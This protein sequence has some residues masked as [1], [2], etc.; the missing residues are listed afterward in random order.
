MIETST[1]F[2]QL[3]MTLFSKVPD[4]TVVVSSEEWVKTI[5]KYD[6]TLNTPS[7][8]DVNLRLHANNIYVYI[9]IYTHTYLLM[10]VDFGTR[11]CKRKH[12]LAC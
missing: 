11:V 3:F 1:N 8:T 7:V 5:Y 2:I 9:H 6:L 10:A 4:T 12:Y